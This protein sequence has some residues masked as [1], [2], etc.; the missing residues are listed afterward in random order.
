MISDMNT[1]LLTLRV[2]KEFGWKKSFARHYVME[3]YYNGLSH[4]TA[5]YETMK[6]TWVDDSDKP[7]VFKF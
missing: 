5:Y 3:R 4:K 6:S 7:K 2:M 1:D